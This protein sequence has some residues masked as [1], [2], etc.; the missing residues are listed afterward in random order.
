MGNAVEFRQQ[1]ISRAARLSA[2]LTLAGSLAWPLPACAGDPHADASCDD[3]HM[4]DFLDRYHQLGGEHQ[5]DLPPGHERV[6]ERMRVSEADLVQMQQ[7][8]RDCHADEFD[9]WQRSGHAVSYAQIFLDRRHNKRLQLNDDCLRCH[10][11]F[12]EGTIR[13]LVTPIDTQGPWQLKDPSLRDRPTIPC[14][15]C[16]QIHASQ[17]LEPSV[18]KQADEAAAHDGPARS[19]FHDRREAMFFPTEQLPPPRVMAEHREVPLSADTRTR[20]CYQCHAPQVTRQA[21]SGDDRTPRGVHAQISC[22]DCHRGHSLDARAS[23]AQ[24]HPTSSHCGLD[25]QRMDTSFRSKS[26]PHDIHTVSCQ[27]CH[28]TGVPPSAP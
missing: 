21:G 7:R 6:R 12:Y 23:C 26:S 3:C 28:T 27:D 19:G 15:A 17:Y 16:H 24:C 1:Q 18:A 10:G 22:F 9:D 2:L 14:S 13:D 11:M 20:L 8:C 5:A 4:Q 25:V